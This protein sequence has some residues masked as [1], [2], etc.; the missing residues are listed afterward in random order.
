MRR[1]FLLIIC[2]LAVL[3]PAL[4]SAND[5]RTTNGTTETQIKSKSITPFTVIGIAARTD[6]AKESTANGI[7]PKQWQKFFS[8][9]IPAKIPHAT[10]PSFYGAYSDYTSDHNGEYA[11]TIG[12]AVKDGTPAPS[13]MAAVRVPAGQY[14]IFTTEIGPFSKVIPEAL[15]HIFKLEEEGRLTQSGVQD[16]FR[17]LRSACA[18]SAKRTD[19]HLYWAEV[20]DCGR[21]RAPVAPQTLFIP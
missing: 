17:S 12:Q 16:G 14:A 19:R 9:G 4:V 7:I 2:G 1:Y 10:G 3:G 6:N 20:N 15:Q 8:E 13:G 11:Y 5:Q 18:K 21:A